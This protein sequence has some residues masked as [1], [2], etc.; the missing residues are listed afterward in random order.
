MTKPLRQAMPTVAAWID[1]LR[2]AFGKELIDLA[3][4]AGIDGQQTF[5]A[6]ENGQ[7]VGTPIAYD[8]NKAVRLSDIIVGPMNQPAAKK[9]RHG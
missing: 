8:A 2:A 9:A 3:I 4:R 1:D 7:Q 6:R 5:H